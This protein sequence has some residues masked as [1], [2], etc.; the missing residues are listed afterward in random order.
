MNK[1]LAE[2]NKEKLL[3]EKS[4]LLKMLKRDSVTDSEIPGGHKPKFNEVGSEQGEN[5]FEV[6]QF[7]N[8]LSVVEDLEE[9]LK[10][11]ETALQKITDGTYGTCEQG[12]EIDEARLRAEPAAT[13]CLKH[14][15]NA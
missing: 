3:G 1:Q 13:T 4:R 10:Q 12:D 7:G 5:A 11:V 15:A 6:E 9:R 2:E 14:A 8:E